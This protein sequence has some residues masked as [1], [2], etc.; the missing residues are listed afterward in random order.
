MKYGMR[1]TPRWTATAAASLALVAAFTTPSAAQIVR[2]PR[3]P[4]PA[5]EGQNI[6]VILPA[7]WDTRSVTFET[8]GLSEDTFLH[9]AYPYQ[10]DCPADSSCFVANLRTDVRN[11]GLYDI[12]FTATDGAGRTR[13]VSGTFEI[14]KPEDRDGD[15]LP[16]LWES[17]HSVAGALGGADD[18]PDG[19]GV[20]NLEEFRRGTHPLTRHV[21]YFGESSSGDRQGMAPC[22][23]I[24]ELTTELPLRTRAARVRLVGDDGRQIV[25]DGWSAYATCPMALTHFV[26][27]R[28]VAIEVESEVPVAVERSLEIRSGFYA[29]WEAGD[30]IHAQA[31]TQPSREWHFAQG[32]T[33]DPIDVFLLAY[34]PQDA[35][36]E[37]EY[38]FYGAPGERPRV[39]TRTLAPRAR[40]TLWVN[41][42]LPGLGAGNRG[43]SVRASAP[44]LMDRGLRWHPPGRTAPHE[45]SSAGAPATAARW[46]FPH[47]D[48]LR[49]SDERLVI[50]NPTEHPTTV[51][52]TVVHGVRAPAVSRVSVGPMSQVSVRAADFGR[53]AIVGVVV[54]STTGVPVVVELAQGGMTPF[55]MRWAYSAPGVT[56]PATQW[57]FPNLRTG[58]HGLDDL[59][60][61]LVLMNP[62]SSDADVEVI[63]SV[64]VDD[65]SSRSVR[66]LVRVPAGRFTVMRIAD[67]EPS[68]TSPDRSGTLSF[69]IPSAMIRSLPGPDGRPATPIVAART[70]RVTAGGVRGARVEHTILP[71]VQ[72]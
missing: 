39:A 27:D 32:S 70:S 66:Y 17:Q 5:G 37:A 6:T 18:D 46:Y 28:V 49:Q 21:Q 3:T 64:E 25:V 16:D 58:G 71:R 47:V 65:V 62:S 52:F 2:P 43:V 59:E 42:D 26:A 34:N 67:V 57:A 44:I 68:P 10:H 20:P 72:P 60:R 33:A 48:A 14:G 55:G 19:D 50:G 53:D 24:R 23:Y 69:R 56:E 31:A 54:T 36:V 12:E 30:L 22:V 13:T 29:Y 63:G 40:T 35:A 61:G 7:R 4:P 45:S 1:R 9:R 51:E 8:R 38:T 11:R 15:G 41:A